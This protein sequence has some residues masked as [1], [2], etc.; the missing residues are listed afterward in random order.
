[1]ENENKFNLMDWIKKSSEYDRW[2]KAKKIKGMPITEKK[3]NG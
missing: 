3:Q 2:V 1:M